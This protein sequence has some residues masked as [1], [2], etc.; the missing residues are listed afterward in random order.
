MN[1]GKDY[2]GLFFAVVMF[3]LAPLALVAFLPMVDVPG[4]LARIYILQHYDQV[5]Q[6]QQTY[7]LTGKWLP[8]LTMDLTILALAKMMTLQEAARVFVALGMVVFALGCWTVSYAVH[9]RITPLAVL[10]LF[11]QYNSSFFYGFVAFQFGV[12]VALCAIGLWYRWHR[13]WNAARVGALVVLGLITYSSHLGGYAFLGLAA[14]WLTLRIWREEKRISLA[15]LIGLLPL[16]PPLLIYLRLGKAPGQ[17][18]LI[19]FSTLSL[20]LRHAAMLLIGYDGYVDMAVAL[21]LLAAVWAGWRYGTYRFQPE[22]VSLAIVFA[23]AFLALPWFVLTASDVDTR[24]VLGIG[25]F[26]LLGLTCDLPPATGKLIYGL[27]LLALAARICFCGWVWSRQSELIAGHAAFLDQIPEG[28]RV[29][30]LAHFPENSAANKF[31]RVLQHVPDLATAQ[32]RAIVA[33]TFAV[34]GQ[35]SIVERTPRW[36][37][38]NIDPA[39]PEAFDWERVAKEYDVI[40]QYGPDAALRAVLDARFRLAGEHGDARLYQSKK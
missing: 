29:Y 21:L 26:L 14:G 15:S 12:A 28:A 34:P 3:L 38:T 18:G 6:F 4:H 36:Y 39:H 25:V 1:G 37:Q 11:L 9:G 13:Q 40:W 22:M 7:E 20:K 10:A 35:H 30:P 24:M 23:I 8:H 32:R 19:Q 31:E 2:R 33:T 27:A 17:Q 16:I 5:P